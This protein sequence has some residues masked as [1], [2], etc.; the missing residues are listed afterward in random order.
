MRVRPASCG[1]KWTIRCWKSWIATF[2]EL[3]AQREQAQGKY[4]AN[5]EI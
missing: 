1:T 2:A 4:V 3:A 5:W